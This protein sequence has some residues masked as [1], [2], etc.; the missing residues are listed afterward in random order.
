MRMSNR[1]EIAAQSILCALMYPPWPPPPAVQVGLRCWEGEEETRGLSDRRGFGPAPPFV[2]RASA[3][4]GADTA[5]RA[6]TTKK[7]RS[8]MA[9]KKFVTYQIFQTG[10]NLL[11][12]IA[13]PPRCPSVQR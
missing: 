5:K 11:G 12:Q 8:A 9:S 6:A 3:P 4:D 13:S 10:T 1:V 2:T 7:A